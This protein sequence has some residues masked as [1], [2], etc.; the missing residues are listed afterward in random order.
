MTTVEPILHDEIIGP[1]S[2]ENP[3]NGEGAIV[4]LRDDRLLL[5]W[6]RFTGG[7]EDHSAAD[8]YG[9]FSEDGGYTWG[10]PFP[11]QE[12]VGARNVMSV[13][14]LRSRSGD[15]LFGFAIKHHERQDCRYYV[16]RSTDEGITWSDAVLTTREEGYFVVNNDRLVQTSSGRLLIPVAKAVDERYHSISACFYSDDDGATWQRSPE[17][18]DLPG[19]VGLQE[20]GVI[21]CADGSLWMYMRTD[22][23]YIYGS[24]SYDDGQ[25]WSV[26][27]PTEL[28]AP[29]SP[30][31]AKRRA[32]RQRLVQR[33][34]LAHAPLFSGEQRLRA[35][36]AAPQAR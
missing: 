14:L 28:V 30:A 3:R 9:R 35:H 23:G 31:S 18:I 24:R 36:L 12:N 16:R 6:T 27:E 25:T 19:A 22:H 7:R 17:Y 2:S 34:Q 10:E 21:E 26:A 11:L 15:L 8:I 13:G 33:F 29:I 32:F 4:T 20:P 5:A 1:V